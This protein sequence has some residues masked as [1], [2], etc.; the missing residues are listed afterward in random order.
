[1]NHQV[2]GR[3]QRA[4]VFKFKQPLQF[5]T[6]LAICIWLLYQISWPHNKSSTSKFSNQHSILWR[7]VNIGLLIRRNDSEGQ[8][9]ID[10]SRTREGED[11]LAI[12]HKEKV[13]E[14]LNEISFLVDD[15]NDEGNSVMQRKNLHGDGVASLNKERPAKNYL[16]E[17][18]HD[19]MHSFMWS[20]QGNLHSE[21]EIDGKKSIQG[22]EVKMVLNKTGKHK[23]VL[24]LEYTDALLPDRMENH[25]ENGFHASGFDDENGVPSGLYY[26]AESKGTE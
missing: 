12:S 22:K 18:Y 3:H 16:N 4:R 9:T 5:A 10:K 6:L 19:S 17:R 11:K 7:K 20:S 14:H 25:A 2:V 23:L 8:N 13:D 15:K 26:V 1:M 24:E 21:A